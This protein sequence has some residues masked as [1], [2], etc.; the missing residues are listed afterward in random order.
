MISSLTKLK[1]KVK[2]IQ[3][4]ESERLKKSKDIELRHLRSRLYKFNI[5]KPK[6]NIHAHSNI[7]VSYLCCVASLLNFPPSTETLYLK[8]KSVWYFVHNPSRRFILAIWRFIFF[9]PSAGSSEGKGFQYFQI[10]MW[11]SPEDLLGGRERNL[12]F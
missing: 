3:W 5:L 1:A 10:G 7:V 8:K 2:W 11:G 6:K 4:R 12:L 9:F